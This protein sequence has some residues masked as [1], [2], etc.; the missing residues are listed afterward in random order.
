M[1][2]SRQKARQRRKEI[3]LVHQEEVERRHEATRL[4][5]AQPKRA[6]PVGPGSLLAGMLGGVKA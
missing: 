3:R 6:A 5:A 4:R 1:S 2:R